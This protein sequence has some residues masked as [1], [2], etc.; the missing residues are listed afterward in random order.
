MNAHA[1]TEELLEGSFSMRSVSYQRK[2]GDQ[3]FPEQLVKKEIFDPVYVNYHGKHHSPDYNGEGG[4][5][6]VSLNLALI[7]ILLDDYDKT[8]KFRRNS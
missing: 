1:T 6:K 5:V 2:V 3:F 8:T 4:G 7:R